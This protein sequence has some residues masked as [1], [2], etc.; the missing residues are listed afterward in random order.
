MSDEKPWQES[1]F[2]TIIEDA[3]TR[4]A[5]VIT[6]I[7]TLDAQALGLLRLYTT[8]GIATVSGGIAG[9]IDSANIVPRPLAWSLLSVSIVLLVGAALCL[10]CLRS[11]KVNL[12]GRDPDFW[13]WAMRP[14]VGR[15]QVLAGYLENLKTKAADN[16]ATNDISS[17]ALKAAKVCCVIAPL[18][19]LVVG[20][21]TI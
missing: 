8:L 20:L 1:E 14:D 4:H 11:T 13:Q 7:Y 5:A 16:L 21:S 10:L 9:L 15:S 19:A 17:K 6:L 2:R 18:V 12:P 3:R